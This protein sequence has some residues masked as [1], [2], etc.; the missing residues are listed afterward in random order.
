VGHIEHGRRIPGR[1]VAHGI[2]AATRAWDEGPITS[3]EWDEDED[4]ARASAGQESE[5]A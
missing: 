5:V 1:R 2:E 3:R 4:E